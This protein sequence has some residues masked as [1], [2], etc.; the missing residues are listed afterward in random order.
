MNYYLPE[1]I[2]D[3]LVCEDNPFTLRRLQH[4]LDDMRREDESVTR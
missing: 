1:E 2:E 4:A 3:A